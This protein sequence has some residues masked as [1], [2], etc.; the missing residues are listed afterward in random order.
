MLRKFVPANRSKRAWLSAAAIA[1][2]AV[3]LLFALQPP[4]AE[5]HCDSYQGPVALAAQHAL[6]AGDVDLVLPYV[7]ADL[8]ADLT[9]AFDQAF[10]VRAMGGEAQRL[11]DQFFIETAV[12][13]HR[14]GEGAPYTGLKDEPVPEAIAV[15]DQAMANGSLD[16]VYQFLD[17]AMRT[18]VEENY[19]KVI[20]ARDLAE[21][22][23][24]VEAN[25]ERVEAELSFEKYIYSL[26]QS[27]TAPV[28]HEGETTAEHH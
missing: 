25:R 5:A 1:V 14:Q 9:S 3:T 7:S 8:E 4:E 24:T 28:G 26:H 21:K 22:K 20:E 12:R 6:E 18:G 19:H 17:D 13:L 23:G 16:G 2:L 10:A 27:I 15:A 11:A